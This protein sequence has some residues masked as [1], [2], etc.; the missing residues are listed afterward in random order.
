MFEMKTLLEDKIK[1]SYMVAATILGFFAFFLLI[2]HDIGGFSSLEQQIIDAHNNMKLLDSMAEYKQYIG[3][4]NSQFSESKGANWL[5]ELLTN[6][7]KDEN[8]TL[9]TIKPLETRTVADYKIVR[10]T[11]DGTATY[12]NLLR[13]VKTL[14]GYK[15][16]IL[17]EQLSVSVHEIS[18]AFSSPGLIAPGA[19]RTQQ[20][21]ESTRIAKFAL[22]I[23]LIGT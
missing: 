18:P 14:E 15:K 10:I 20:E 2:K 11:A 4:F 9:G 8:I 3:Q 13:L 19:A 5:V 23:A 1:F 17:I 7:S 16:Y 22:R 21:M 12:Q 6:F